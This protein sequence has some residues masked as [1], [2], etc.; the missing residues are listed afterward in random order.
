VPVS[1]KAYNKLLARNEN[2]KGK[3]KKTEEEGASAIQKAIDAAVISAS[4]FGFGWFESRYPDKSAILGVPVSLAVAGSAAIA[5]AMG[6][7]GADGLIE[8]VG[9]GALASF[10]T[11]KG[12]QYGAEARQKALQAGVD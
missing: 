4:A 12:A 11:R 10:A 2:L 7:E 5:S 3:L 8:S 1:E 6:V 9:A